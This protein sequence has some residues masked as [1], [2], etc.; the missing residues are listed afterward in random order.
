MDITE[1]SPDEFGPE[2]R[3]A[4]APRIPVE[5]P[6]GMT[7]SIPEGC[8]PLDDLMVAELDIASRQLKHDVYACVGQKDGD[9]RYWHA[10]ALLAWLWAKRLDPKAKLEPF[11][12]L[13]GAQLTEVLR[14]NDLPDDDSADDA[15][16][17]EN[18]TDSAPAS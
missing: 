12:Q 3:P 9:G 15:S 13:K 6:E 14:L 7:Y 1:T 11:R 5:L 18:P 16:A 2:S 17:E 10:L 4:N 8:D